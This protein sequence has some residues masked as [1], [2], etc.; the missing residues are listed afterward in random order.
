MFSFHLKTGYFILFPFYKNEITLPQMPVYTL[1]S[2]LIEMKEC[3][4]R[5]AQTLRLCA[6]N[7]LLS[8][9]AFSI[10]I[11]IRLLL[12]MDRIFM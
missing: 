1:A 9:G 6:R 4:L 5:I 11:L 7:H 10:K 12:V 2:S 3:V 8:L